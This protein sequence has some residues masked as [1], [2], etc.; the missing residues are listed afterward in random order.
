MARRP[1]KFARAEW[2]SET[3]R[4]L[5]FTRE[6]SSYRARPGMIGKPAASAEVHVCGLRRFLRKSK[7]APLQIVQ[8]LSAFLT[9]RYDSYSR[10]FVVS[11][12][13]T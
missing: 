5:D 3:E 4:M 11:T 13:S 12:T 2:S 10:Q 9:E 1:Q 8:E 7:I 6:V